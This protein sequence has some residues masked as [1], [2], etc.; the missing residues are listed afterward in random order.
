VSERPLP[1]RGEL[2][3]QAAAVSRAGLRTRRERLVDGARPILQTSVAA[4]LAWLVATELIGHE[5]PFFA[6]VAAVITLGLTIGQRGRRAVEIAIGVALGIA[7][8]D[9]LVFAIGTGTA[10]V[11]I[12]TGLAM[13]A[14]TLIGGGP[15]LAAQAGISAVLV[16]TL[17]PPSTSVSFER[18]LDGLA[19]ATVA[20][21]VGAV[22]LPVDPVRL[23]RRSAAPLIERLSDALDRVASALEARDVDSAER[24]LVRVGEVEPLHRELV[25]AL[26]AAGETARLSPGRRGSLPRLERYA[27]AAGELGLAVENARTIARGA[28]RAINLNDATPPALPQ[29]LRQLAT[30]TRALLP[31]LDGGE[32]AEAR[33]AVERAAELGNRALEQTGNMSAVH[34]AGQLRLLAVDVLRAAGMERGEAQQLVRQA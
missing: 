23:A 30:A 18:A 3:E 21:V 24:G 33:E 32:A 2:L 8:A 31:Y 12:V 5:R 34:L 14:A 22:L 19:G 17:E 28:V 4:A 26:A 25:E 13:L 16:A 27:V 11:A 20:I 1:R 7:I 15:L 10:Q 6:P 29:A 9:L